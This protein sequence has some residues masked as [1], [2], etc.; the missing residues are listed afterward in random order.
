MAAP[1]KAGA[2]GW[3]RV[4]EC[5][6]GARAAPGMSNGTNVESAQLGAGAIKRE[7]RCLCAHKSL[8]MKLQFIATKL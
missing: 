5:A 3:A 6:A 1:E 2:A 8:F 7:A 4:A